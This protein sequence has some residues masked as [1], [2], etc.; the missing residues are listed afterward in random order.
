M[1]QLTITLKG[2]CFWSPMFITCVSNITGK[3]LWPSRNFQYY[4][5]IGMRINPIDFGKNWAKINITNTK[6]VAK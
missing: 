1:H 2:K 3:R 5:V 6:Y 4:I